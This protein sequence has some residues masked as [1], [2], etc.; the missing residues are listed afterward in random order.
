MTYL[1]KTFE[2]WPDVLA[3]KSVEDTEKAQFTNTAC[4]L[5]DFILQWATFTC[6]NVF[7]KEITDHLRKQVLCY[8]KW[9]TGKKIYLPKTLQERVYAFSQMK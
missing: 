2:A 6:E 4:I 8:Y 9:L 3:D 5:F 7:E 1:P